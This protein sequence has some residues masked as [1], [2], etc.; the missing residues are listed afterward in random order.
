[1]MVRD[2]IVL[3]MMFLVRK[4]IDGDNKKKGRGLR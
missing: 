2:F 4:E 3:Y 1:M